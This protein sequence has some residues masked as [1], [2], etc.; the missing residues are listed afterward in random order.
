MVRMCL[1]LFTR[2]VVRDADTNEVLA[3]LTEENQQYCVAEGMG[4]AETGTLKRPRIKLRAT[5][6]REFRAMKSKSY[7]N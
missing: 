5:R 6:N 2:T 4:V 3:E 1:F 7:S